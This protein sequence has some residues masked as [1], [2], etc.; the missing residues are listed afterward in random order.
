MILYLECIP[1]EQVILY[2]QS[3]T[4]VILDVSKLA[5]ALL[6]NSMN[7]PRRIITKDNILLYVYC[8]AS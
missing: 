3:H 6:N 2:C 4:T 8:Q 1:N 7:N 5:K